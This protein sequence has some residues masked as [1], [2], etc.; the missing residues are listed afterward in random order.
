MA[1]VL[2][3]AT[4]IIDV[5]RA[6]GMPLD[7]VAAFAA[8]VSLAEVRPSEEAPAN[9]ILNLFAS[10]GPRDITP[11]DISFLRALYRLPLDRTALA[12]RGL[13]VRGMLDP[14]KQD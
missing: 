9:S 14:T 6:T 7:S 5:N 13:L 8:L 10:D 4:V 3:A 12:Q 2:K 1:R 11:L